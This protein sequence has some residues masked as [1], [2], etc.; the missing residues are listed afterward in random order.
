MKIPQFMRRH[1]LL[2]VPPVVFLLAGV[3]DAV[4]AYIGYNLSGRPQFGY[5]LRGQSIT[6]LGILA[7]SI[8]SWTVLGLMGTS[9]VL[10]VRRFPLI[11]SRW[12][13]VLLLHVPAAM[14][15]SALFLLTNAAFRHFVFVGP[16]TGVSFLTTYLRYY[17][18]YYNIYFIFY[19]SIVGVYSA[20]VYY[21]QWNEKR[22]AEE[23]LQ[24]SVA[25]LRLQAIQAQLQPHFLFNAL[26][27][28][29][30]LALKGDQRGTIHVIGLLG[31]LLRLGLERREHAITLAEE[32]EFVD[33]YMEMQRTRFE[34]RLHFE[35]E[36]E[37]G[38][39]DAEIPSFVLQPLIENAIRHGVSRMEAPGSIVLRAERAGSGIRLTLRDDGAGLGSGMPS[40]HGL[41][42]RLIAE[43]MQQL[44]GAA[45]TFELRPAPGRG[46][47]AVLEWPLRYVRPDGPPRQRHSPAGPRLEP[48]PLSGRAMPWLNDAAVGVGNLNV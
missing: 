47:E 12:Q 45:Y 32:M 46:A 28:I 33:L 1:A 15:F 29:N 11:G 23:K 18:V 31:D 26:N 39:L 3:H 6:L 17:A 9:A 21:A 13:R 48:A 4:H 44:Y 40:G 25:E 42:L 16:E 10:F 2:I 24:R 43:R 27:S 38:L 5:T 7:R 19:C 35:V 20:H 37:P 22:V 30:A 8:P 41:G 36:I 14:L 34:E